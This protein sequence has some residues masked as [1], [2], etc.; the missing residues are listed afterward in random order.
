MLHIVHSSKILLVLLEIL[1]ICLYTDDSGAPDIS[2]DT[3]MHI[4]K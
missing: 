3:Q 4:R 1:E 2:S